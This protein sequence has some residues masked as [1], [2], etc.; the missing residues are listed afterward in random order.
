MT[1]KL[2][3]AA[4]VFCI[5]F[6]SPWPSSA[7][8]V[9]S[10]LGLTTSVEAALQSQINSLSEVIVRPAERT[11]LQ[12]FYAN[13]NNRPVWVDRSGPTRAASQ[14]LAELAKA[15]DWGLN[16]TDYTVRAN[17]VPMSAGPITKGHWTA[18][19]TAAAEYEISALILKYAR[20]AQGGRIA[21]PDRMLS[22]YLDRRPQMSEPGV[23]LSSVAGSA[24]PDAA[25]RSLHPKHEQFQKL[26]D[27]YVKLQGASNGVAKVE[28]PEKGPL[29]VPGMTHDDVVLLRKRMGVAAADGED[30]VYDKALV[31][32]VKSFQSAADLND[33]GFVGP[34]TR[35]ALNGSGDDH[36]AAIRA[37]MEQWRWM[38]EDLGQTHL[39]VNV[40][41]FSIELVENGETTLEERV[42]VG[43]HATATP[44]F[45]KQLTAV[46][47]KPSWI[48]PDSIKLEKLL[49]SQRSGTSIEDEGYLIK[50]GSHVID[51]GDVDWNTA[52][53]KD[54]AIYQPSGDGNA[55]GDVK[56]LF[57]NKHSVY[58]HD[59]P[60]KALFDASARLFSHGCMR[61]RHPL[62]LAQR[63]LDADK[64]DGVWNVKKFVRKGEDNT[65]IMLDTPL[66]IHVAYFTVWIS[67]DGLPQYL[68]DP[69]GH[70]ERITMALNK[71]WNDIDRGVD[72]LAKVDTQQLK[73]VSVQ[74]EAKQ[75]ER[76]VTRPS[77]PAP[78]PALRPTA[79]D[80]DQPAPVRRAK[81]FDPPSGLT[82]ANAGGRKAK[83]FKFARSRSDGGVGEMMRASLQH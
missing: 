26:R 4:A 5:V 40:P 56:F 32:A 6:G 29:L 79:N 10:P 23:V 67:K 8:E 7:L 19:E 48:L 55:L 53:L 37:N 46:V 60:N 69:Y 64:G 33:D 72:H 14:V 17:K 71:K 77:R 47:L 81:N 25:L 59:T 13:R 82:N 78:S 35:K 51:S 3:S 12:T 63:L 41:A 15:G 27:L 80:D 83:V 39:F 30:D 61:L 34:A 21:D 73:S 11:A 58:L 66:P 49:S 24:A 62:A 45:S 76:V 57:P 65:Q 28:M 50:K 20:D 42:I 36:L 38:P 68:G 74:R 22:S 70:E 75:V 54:Y 52:D 16:A 31:Q 43:K 18:A 44:I 1:F 2:A 9:Q